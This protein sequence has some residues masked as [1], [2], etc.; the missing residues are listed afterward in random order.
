MPIKADAIVGPRGLFT[1]PRRASTRPFRRRSPST[2]PAAGRRSHRPCSARRRRRPRAAPA[3]D[4]CRAGPDQSSRTYRLRGASAGRVC[5]LVAVT[6]PV[7]GTTVDPVRVHPPPAQP[8]PHQPDEHVLRVAP[9]LHCG[10]RE[11]LHRNE[12]RFAHQRR[13]GQ[14]LET[15]TRPR[16]STSLRRARCVVGSTPD[17]RCSAGWPGSPPPTTVPPL[18]AAVRIPLRVRRRWA[19]HAPLVQLPG[20]T[21]DAAPGEA[22]ANI[23][24]TCG[25]VTGSGCRRWG[26]RPHAACALFGCGP[27]STSRYPYGGRPPRYRPC[28]TVCAV[29]AATVRYRDRTTS[30]CDCAASTCI[31]TDASGRRDRPGRPPPAATPAPRAAAE[32]GRLARAVAR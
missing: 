10:P 25:A 15:P 19:G 16:P 14:V 32:A 5:A 21:G 20:D 9:S 27:A 1:S 2:R 13:M 17:V 6:A 28:S 7:P 18:P 4:A 31:N 30:R 24:R 22:P 26:R 29:I 3:R 12:V 11:L 23:H 8:A